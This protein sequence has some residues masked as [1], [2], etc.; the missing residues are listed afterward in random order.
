MYRQV[1]TPDKNNHS[2]ELPEELFGKKVEVI[3]VEIGD[4]NSNGGHSSLPAGKKVSVNELLETFGADPDFPT[5]EE[6]RSKAWPS[7]W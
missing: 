1:I 4:T 6:L 3:M 5:I 7:K 2:V